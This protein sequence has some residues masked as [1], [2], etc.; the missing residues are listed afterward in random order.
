MWQRNITYHLFALPPGIEPATSWCMGWHSNQLTATL[1]GQTL[2]IL[3]QG[4]PLTL[5]SL[6]QGMENTHTHTHTNPMRIRL[7]QILCYSGKMHRK[8]IHHFNAFLKGTVLCHK[9]IPTVVRAL[10]LLLWK[11]TLYH[12]RVL[13]FWFTHP[14]PPTASSPPGING[15][16]DCIYLISSQKMD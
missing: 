11:V 3:T 15:L 9:C 13:P 5:P 12:Q 14:H 8:K 7:L 1:P 2:K 16:M 4:C 6:S 10:F